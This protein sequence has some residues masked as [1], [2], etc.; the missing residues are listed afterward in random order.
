[1]LQERVFQVDIQDPLNR[2]V[3]WDHLAGVPKGREPSRPHRIFGDVAKESGEIR[4]LTSNLGKL[5]EEKVLQLWKRGTTPLFPEFRKN[6]LISEL[7]RR[8]SH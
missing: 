7:N 6:M 2:R 5:C 3:S 4:K 8:L 1:M